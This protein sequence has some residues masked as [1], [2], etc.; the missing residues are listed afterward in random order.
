MFFLS[1]SP[2]MSLRGKGP[3]PGFRLLGHVPPSLSWCEG[4][5]RRPGYDP[6]FPQTSL[7]EETAPSEGLA[8]PGTRRGRP[9]MKPALSLWRSLAPSGQQER[10][11]QPPGQS[12]RQPDHSKVGA[13]CGPRAPRCWTPKPLVQAPSGDPVP[14]HPEPMLMWSCNKHRVTEARV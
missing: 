9:T 14:I 8:H 5:A 7:W 12:S 10:S 11:S 6:G 3:S 4:C 1:L 13:E 2:L